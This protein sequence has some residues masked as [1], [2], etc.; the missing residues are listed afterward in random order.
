MRV[1]DGAWRSIEIGLEINHNI[2]LLLYPA[3]ESQNQANK[4]TE[5]GKMENL[6]RNV[7]PPTSG[8]R[9]W[10]PTLYWETQILFIN[11]NRKDVQAALI[12]ASDSIYLGPP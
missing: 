6:E 11:L 2:Y 7:L 8:E 3:D 12:I 9:S 1:E 5:N 4:W 10:P